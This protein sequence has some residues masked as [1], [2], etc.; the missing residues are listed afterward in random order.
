MNYY[1]DIIKSFIVEGTG[2]RGAGA[3]SRGSHR[4][5]SAASGPAPRVHAELATARRC[6][7]LRPQRALRPARARTHAG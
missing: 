4:A 1:E 3:A 5:V 2:Y 6:H 7:V